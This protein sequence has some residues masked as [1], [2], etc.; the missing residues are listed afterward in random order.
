MGETTRRAVVEVR[1][2]RV[3]VRVRVSAFVLET[4]RSI[5]GGSAVWAMVR[6]VVALKH[7]EHVLVHLL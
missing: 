1:V 3:E 6:C 5:E 7:L 4:A 2:V